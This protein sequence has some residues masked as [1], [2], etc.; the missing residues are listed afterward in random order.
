[1]SENP[2]TETRRRVSVDWIAV[3]VAAAVAVLAATRLLPDIP[4]DSVTIPLIK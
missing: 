3:G 4:W 2:E 1:M